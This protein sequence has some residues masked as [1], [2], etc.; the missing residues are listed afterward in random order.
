MFMD[1]RKIA[2]MI[3]VLIGQHDLKPLIG[4]MRA[5]PCAAVVP[6]HLPLGAGRDLVA[7]DG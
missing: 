3:A 2:G 1:I 5:Y 6:S 4:L 7:P